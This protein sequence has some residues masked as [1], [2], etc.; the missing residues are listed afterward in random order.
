LFYLP[1]ATSVPDL[2]A[3]AVSMWKTAGIRRAFTYGHLRALTV[4]ASADELAQAERL[5][6]EREER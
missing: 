5:I 2:R 6:K 4:R 1:A 3:T